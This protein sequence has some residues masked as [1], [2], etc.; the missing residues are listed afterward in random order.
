MQHKKL[1]LTIGLIYYN[2][3][4]RQHNDQKSHN[5]IKEISKR[6]CVIMGGINLGHIQWKY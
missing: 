4:I 5:A 1:A 3:D 2:P 6:E